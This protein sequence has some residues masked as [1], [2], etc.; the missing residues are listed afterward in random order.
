M[1]HPLFTQD[2]VCYAYA[3]RWVID[4]SD[5]I[6]VIKPYWLHKI[7]AGMKTVELRSTSCH[8][9]VGLTIWLAA[10]GTSAVFA[11]AV[12][13]NCV[14]INTQQDLDALRHEHCYVGDLPYQP[15]YAWK[16][17]N[18]TCCPRP[19]AIQRKRGS[20]VWQIGP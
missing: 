11:K 16:L 2:F 12:I 7:L 14:A 17:V 9:K 10:S 18:V 15:T 8:S 20:V 3:L 5:P 13:S 19:I 4:A 1:L 6:L